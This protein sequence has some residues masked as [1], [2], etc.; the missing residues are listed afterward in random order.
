MEIG[1]ESVH[2]ALTDFVGRVLWRRRILIGAGE[3]QS[4]YVHIAEEMIRQA[5]TSADE[6]GIRVFG[7]GLALP[8]LVDARQGELRYAPMLRWRGAPIGREWSERFELPVYVENNA[9]AAAIGEYYFGAA[10]DVSDFIYIGGEPG[11]G[12]GIV[13]EGELLRGRS[14]FAGEIGHMTVVPD[15]ELCT[16]GK[17]GCWE[18]VVGPQAVIADYQRRATQFNGGALVDVR[19][20]GLVE[21]AEAARLPDVAAG[22]ALREAARYLGIGI[23][24][25]VNVLNPEMVVLG[26][27]LGEIGEALIPVVR[28]T[29]KEESLFPMRDA[30]SIL[31]SAH[32]A[33]D[34]VLGAVALV[35][36]QVLREPV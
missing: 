15:G 14:G 19:D 1:P 9:N 33:D 29:V 27:A 34:C 11:I 4:T 23:A 21:M 26:G 20:I 7:L 36:D 13:V 8:G 25:L 32:G 30:L 2:V 28:D 22:A 31:P 6:A 18:T 10:R 3:E 5:M 17:R 35:L 16:C 12:G 24:N